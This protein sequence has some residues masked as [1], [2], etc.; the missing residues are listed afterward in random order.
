VIQTQ[1]DGEENQATGASRTEAP[2]RPPA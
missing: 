2:R 1:P